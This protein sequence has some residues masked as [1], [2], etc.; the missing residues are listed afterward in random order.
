MCI[1]LLINR[2]KWY[3][4][5]AENVNFYNTHM[6]TVIFPIKNIPPS[7]EILLQVCDTKFPSDSVLI[8]ILMYRL[9]IRFMFLIYHALAAKSIWWTYRYCV[10]MNIWLNCVRITTLQ[11]FDWLILLIQILVRSI[12][13]CLVNKSNQQIPRGG[14]HADKRVC[15]LGCERQKP[16]LGWPKGAGHCNISSKTTPLGNYAALSIL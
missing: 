12:L 8:G 7:S 10:R 1:T 2:H 11:L 14:Q 13:N 3:S 16:N 15:A 9:I 4:C 5:H 6:F